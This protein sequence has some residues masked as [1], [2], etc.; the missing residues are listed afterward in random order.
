MLESQKVQERS[1]QT[2]QTH[3][4][5]QLQRIEPLK[6]KC[7]CYRADRTLCPLRLRDIPD[8]R[9]VSRFESH[10][11]DRNG[12]LKCTRSRTGMTGRVDQN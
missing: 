1:P 9:H 4:Y 3:I 10:S 6:I 12:H 11:F 2:N 8:E 7:Y 5:K